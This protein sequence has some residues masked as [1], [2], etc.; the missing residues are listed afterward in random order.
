MAPNNIKMRTTNS[1]VPSDMLFSKGRRRKVLKSLQIEQESN[2]RAF[3]YDS[4]Q[5][6]SGSHA[7]VWP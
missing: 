3:L 1:M 6:L 4:E 2:W 5:R 7:M